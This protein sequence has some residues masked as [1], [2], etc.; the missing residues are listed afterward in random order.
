MTSRAFLRTSVS[1]LFTR[2]GRNHTST[3]CSPGWSPGTIIRFSSAVIWLNS[4]AIWKVRSMPM[5]NSWCG[6][7][8][9]TSAPSNIT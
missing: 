9:V 4:C 5:P 7:R 3:R 2:P 6:G 1:R 8:P